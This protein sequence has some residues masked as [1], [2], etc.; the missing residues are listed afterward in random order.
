MVKLIFLGALNSVGASGI[1]V[2]TGGAGANNKRI[3]LDY[4]ADVQEIPQTYPHDIKGRVDAIFLTHSNLDHSGGVALLMKKNKCPIYAL[5]INKPLVEI[6]LNDS[7]K[8]AKHENVPIPFAKQDVHKA[9]RYFSSM[10]YK[11]PVHVGKVKAIAYDAGHIPGSMMAYL[12]F[13]EN[14]GDESKKEK[15]R[16]ILYTGDFNTNRTRLLEPAEEDLP[17]ID[18]LITE[19][20]Y[21]NRDHSDREEEEKK[22]VR[23]VESTIADGGI[24]LISNFAIGRTQEILL[25]LNKYGID[26]PLYMDGM[27]KKATT[28]INNFPRFMR[29]PT[30]LDKALRKVQYIDNERHRKNAI[31]SPCA[32][33]TTSGMLNGGPIVWYIGKLY[34][35]R[36]NSL[37]LTGFQVEGSVGKTLL[38]TGRFVLDKDNLKLK[39]PVTRLDF[40]SHSGR[41]ELFA[42]V[43][44]VSPKKIFCVH[45]ENTP[46]FAE[47]LKGKGFD[48]VAPT[49][50]KRVFDL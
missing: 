19:S 30:E 26:Y 9:L 13:G 3:V 36:R 11:T 24:A 2:E 39:M 42:F 14:K 8:I 28:A 29:E 44:K 37:V 5:P 27:A 48:A 18:V 49:E 32:V 25:I 47:E 23:I 22:L 4:G 33:L 46:Q 34:N 12:E 40:S 17:E 41:K 45:G 21:A 35:D 43:E 15:F 16:N 20:T 31:K 10:E 38:D 1:L 7:I 50:E 6:L